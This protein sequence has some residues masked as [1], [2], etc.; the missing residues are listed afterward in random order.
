MTALAAV[1][2]ALAH[3]AAHEEARRRELLLALGFVSMGCVLRCFH[4]L[5]PLPEGSGEELLRQIR[6]HDDRCAYLRLP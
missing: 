4:R 5:P 1:A 2:I 6:E 3:P